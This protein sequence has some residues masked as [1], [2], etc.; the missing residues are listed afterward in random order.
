MY[1]GKEGKFKI[2]TLWILIIFY[3]IDDS[4]QFQSILY[5]FTA[6]VKCNFASYLL[7]FNLSFAH[8]CRYIAWKIVKLYSSLLYILY[9]LNIFNIYFIILIIIIIYI[10]YILIIINLIYINLYNFKII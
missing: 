2:A 9:I 8:H 3:H 5:L 4:H 10:Y 7:S 1:S 6:R